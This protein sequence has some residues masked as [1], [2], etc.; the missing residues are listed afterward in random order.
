MKKDI[1]SLDGKVVVF[2]GGCGNLGQPM[3]RALL[4]YGAAVAVPS[5]T[6]KF[7]ES[8]DEYKKA[9]KLFF[10]TADLSETESIKAAFAEIFEINEPAYRSCPWCS[11]PQG[12]F[13]QAVNEMLLQGEGDDLRFAPAVPASWRD[14]AFRLRAPG[15]KTVE[16]VFRD[17]ACV[18]R[19][20][21]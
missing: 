4:E 21:E 1:F 12:T 9:D 5:R 20:V 14:F 18:K 8:F 11:S 10:V 6:D 7:D 19:T 16:A 3:V 17:G 15:G 13:V 2:T